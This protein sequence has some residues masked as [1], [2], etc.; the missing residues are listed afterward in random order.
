MICLF[1]LQQ[2]PVRLIRELQAKHALN[3]PI[4]AVAHAATG[5]FL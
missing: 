1:S 2:F 4:L 3:W 5:R